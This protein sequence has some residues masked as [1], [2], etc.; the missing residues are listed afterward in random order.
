MVRL[1]FVMKSVYRYGFI[2][3]NPLLFSCA[4]SDVIVEQLEKLSQ[5]ERG[6]FLDA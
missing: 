6:Q 3:S 1:I 2:I 4:L 5:L